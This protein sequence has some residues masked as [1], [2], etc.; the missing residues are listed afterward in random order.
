MTAPLPPLSAGTDISLAARRHDPR[1][2][3]TAQQL[4]GLFVQQLF[5]A[6]RDTVPTDG[7]LSGGPGGEM[8]TAML[9]EHLAEEVPA[10]WDRGLASNI[11][12]QMAAAARSARSDASAAE[13]R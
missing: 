1:L 10:R 5:A 11:A 7:P 4:E 12:A 9:H 13:S 6:M 2:T 8:F 3:K